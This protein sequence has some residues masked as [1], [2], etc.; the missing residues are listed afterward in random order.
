MVDET[1]ENADEKLEEGA[2]VKTSNG[3]SEDESTDGV[4]DRMGDI[5]ILGVMAFIAVWFQI[6]LVV[7]LAKGGINLF[8]GIFFPANLG[9]FWLVYVITQDVFPGRP[10]GKTIALAFAAEAI[11]LA[12]IMGPIAV[13]ALLGSKFG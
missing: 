11:S 4:N 12:A 3:E 1:I 2:A 5:V 7:A 13:I 8:T 9:I 10:R 6:G